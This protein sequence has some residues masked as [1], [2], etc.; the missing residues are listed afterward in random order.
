MNGIKAVVIDDNGLIRDIVAR[1]LRAHGI[2]TQEAEDAVSGWRAIEGISPQ[3]AVLDVV[4]P[5]EIDG[6]GLCRMIRASTDYK[7][8]AIVM[9]TASD[10]RKE[11]ERSLAAGADVLIGKPFSPKQ[12]WAQVYSLLKDKEKKRRAAGK[13]G[14]VSPDAS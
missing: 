5:G 3:L 2:E 14:F 9:I 8:C 6:V 10:K 12:F 1:T 11:A 7:D 13:A 4:L